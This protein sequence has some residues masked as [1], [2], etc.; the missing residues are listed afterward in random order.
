M[1]SPRTHLLKTFGKHFS[2]LVVLELVCASERP[3]GLIK[4]QIEPSEFSVG[5][6]WSLRMCISNTFPD[7][8]DADLGPCFENHSSNLGYLYTFIIH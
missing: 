5:L 4:I 2:G 1:Q 6:G 7:D 3:K 8:V